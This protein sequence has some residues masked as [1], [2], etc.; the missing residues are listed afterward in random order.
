MKIK[1]KMVDIINLLV[2]GEYQ[3]CLKS[4]NLD[5]NKLKLVKKALIDGKWNVA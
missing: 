2:F 5:Q 3:E 1:V 4:Y